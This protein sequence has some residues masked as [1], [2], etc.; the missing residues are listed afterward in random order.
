MQCN[1]SVLF[2]IVFGD[3]L[4]VVL[5]CVA[6]HFGDVLYCDELFLCCVALHLLTNTSA[7]HSRLECLSVVKS[8]CKVAAAAC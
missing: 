1:M 6:L 8:Q 5:H 4:R 3:M 2:C 7:L